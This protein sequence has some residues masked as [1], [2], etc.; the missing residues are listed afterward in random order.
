[1]DH[2][3]EILRLELQ[4]LNPEVRKSNVAL[5]KLLAD[6]FIEY[7]SSGRIYHKAD[8][9]ERLPVES[10]II[11][12]L[13]DVKAVLLAPKVCLVTYKIVEQTA[14][15]RCTLRSSIWKNQKGHWQLYFHQGTVHYH[16]GG[17]SM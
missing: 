4:L 14:E 10:P 7:G 3:Q 1:M 12:T 2:E 13:T 17:H 11:R 5:E 9:L 8:I 16:D 15:K 6:D